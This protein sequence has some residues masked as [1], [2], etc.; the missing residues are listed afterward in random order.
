MTKLNYSIFLKIQKSNCDKTQI[1]MVVIVTVVTE[2]VRVIYFGKNN[3]LD[4]LTSV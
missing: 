3:P 1:G 4:T 2:V